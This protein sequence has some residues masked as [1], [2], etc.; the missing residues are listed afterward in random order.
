[1]TTALVKIMAKL[2]QVLEPL[3]LDHPQVFAKKE[4]RERASNGFF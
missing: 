4:S 3:Y 1:M 2:S